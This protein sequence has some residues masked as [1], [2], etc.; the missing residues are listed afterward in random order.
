MVPKTHGPIPINR[1]LNGMTAQ[2]LHLVRKQYRQNLKDRLYILLLA[3]VA[4]LICFAIVRSK[5]EG[6]ELPDWLFMITAWLWL[7]FVFYSCW[8]LVGFFRAAL[9]VRRD[10][11]EYVQFAPKNALYYNDKMIKYMTGDQALDIKWE[12][13]TAFFEHGDSIFLTPD[14]KLLESIY[15][16]RTDIGDEEYDKLRSFIAT[17]IS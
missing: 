15:F 8:D 14:K 9:R 17:K 10:I 11:K 13:V 4:T 6:Y 12:N 7:G 3:S 2:A 5:G 1:S 16:S